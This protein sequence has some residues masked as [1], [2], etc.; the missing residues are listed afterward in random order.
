MK[1]R[2]KI[3]AEY[4]LDMRQY[5]DEIRNE[6]SILEDL[7]AQNT[8]M[9]ISNRDNL[10]THK[11]TDEQGNEKFYCSATKNWRKID[12]NVKDHHSLHYAAAQ[13]IYLLLKNK[14]TDEWEFPTI[15]LN[16]QDSFIQKRRE[17]FNIISGNKW[18]AKPIYNGPVLATLRPFTEYEKQDKKNSLLCG[19]RTYYFEASHLRGLPEFDFDA[20]DYKDYAWVTKADM[21]KFLTKERFDIFQPSFKHR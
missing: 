9:S 8:Y 21:N 13:R 20:C 12:P 3:M 16:S 7:N 18:V 2:Q 17:L 6:A 4:H 5:L 14:Y 19:V 11:M 15:T 1:L 10:P